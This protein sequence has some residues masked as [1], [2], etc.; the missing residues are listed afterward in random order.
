MDEICI[1]FQIRCDYRE[2]LVRGYVGVNDLHLVGEVSQFPHV[3]R[4]PQTL[5]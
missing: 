4:R 3:R 1:D 5:H 2:T